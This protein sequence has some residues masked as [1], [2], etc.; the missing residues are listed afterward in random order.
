MKRNKICSLLLAA[1]CGSCSLDYENT[2]TINPDNVW[3]NETMINA[4]LTNIYGKMLPGWPVSAN[5]TD[6]GMNGPTSMGDQARGLITV[7]N[8]GQGLDYGNIDRINFFLEQLETQTVV[9]GV[10]K[11]NMRGQALFWRAWDYWGKVFS[12]GGVP[13]ILQFQDVTDTESLF[14]PRNSTTECVTQILKDLDEAISLL[15]DTWEG[16]D[17]GRIDKGCAMAFKGRVLLQYASPLFNPNNDQQRW[18]DA[19]DANKAAVDFLQSVGKGLYEGDFADIWYDEQN[20]EVIM[21]NQFYYPDHSFSQ[22]GIRPEPLTNGDANKNQAILPLLLAFP[23]ADGTP[24]ELD[25]NRLATD[26]AYNEQFM[27]D[28]YTNRDPRFFATVF[29]PGTE[30]F[31]TDVLMNGAKYWNTMKVVVDESGEKYVTMIQDQL[32]KGEGAR[33]TGYFQ[34]KGLDDLIQTEIGNAET[35]WIEIRFAEVLMNYGECA[36]EL[37]KSGEALQVLYD[38]RKRAGIQS[39]DSRYGITA[40]SQDEIREAY[41]NERFIEFAYEGKRFGD[42]R[43][44]K[45]FDILNNLKYRSC[46]YPVIKDNNNLATFDWTKDMYDPEVRK[47]FRFDYI[48]CADMDKQYMFNYD[49]NHWFYPIKKDDLDRNSKLEQNNEWGGTFDPLK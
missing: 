19:Y 20:K 37:G 13:L 36:N 33:S 4:F 17:Y 26:E 32:N 21:V 31:C 34:K 41:I 42:L 28:F 7:D 29:C 3:Q 38:I 2:G 39:V 35:D 44:W 46:L 49:L 6:E 12:I 11:D 43:R 8:Q 40:T 24:L 5:N 15:P 47:L 9:S 23:E 30:Y 22:A 16:D 10:K 1:I 25:V 48:E 18:Q 27:T 45:R 14:V